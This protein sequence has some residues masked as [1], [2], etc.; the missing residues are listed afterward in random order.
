MNHLEIINGCIN[1]DRKAQRLLVEEFAPVLTAICK[2][3]APDHNHAYDCLQ[4][5]FIKIFQNIES[6]EHNG[7]FEGWLKKITIRSCFSFR[8]KIKPVHTI[9]HL[10]H[11]LHNVQLP[12]AIEKLNEQ[13]LLA[14]IKQLPENQYLVFSMFAIEGYSHKEIAET[15]GLAESSSRSILTR[16][17]IK[18]IQI[19]QEQNYL[20]N[21]DSVLNTNNSTKYTHNEHI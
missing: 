16:A 3:Y 8:K 14:I 7:S 12:K 2:R 5:S 4:E 6:F 15:L 1:K 13:E 10:D 17:R 19:L 21:S 20:I 18:L 9:D 11:S